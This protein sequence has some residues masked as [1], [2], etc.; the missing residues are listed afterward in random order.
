MDEVFKRRDN[1]VT[2]V[3]PEAQGFDGSVAIDGR[4]CVKIVE[5]SIA[6][7]QIGGQVGKFRGYSG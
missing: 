4:I 3:V 5:G 7:P 1:P 2:G 6:P